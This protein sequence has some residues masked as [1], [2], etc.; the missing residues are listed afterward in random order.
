M[1]G[2]W[3]FR[4][5]LCETYPIIQ[6]LLWKCSGVRRQEE[7]FAQQEYTDAEQLAQR[8]SEQQAAAYASPANA[9]SSRSATEKCRNRCASSCKCP[10]LGRTGLFGVGCSPW[11]WFLTCQTVTLTLPQKL[12]FHQRAGRSLGTDWLFIS[13]IT[14]AM[15]PW[16]KQCFSQEKLV[17]AEEFSSVISCRNLVLQNCGN[18]I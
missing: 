3:N 11:F 5:G 7:L 16:E 10:N 1:S 9:H 12:A 15:V 18:N 6:W 17:H 14:G 13:D 2:I 4:C 8:D